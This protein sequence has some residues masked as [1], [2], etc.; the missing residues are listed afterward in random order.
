[1]KHDI[2]QS[3]QHKN[4]L[5]SNVKFKVGDLIRVSALHCGERAFPATIQE[6]FP[7]SE[8]DFEM[9]VED[10]EEDAFIVHD[11]LFGIVITNP[12]ICQQS[13]FEAF[14]WEK[15]YFSNGKLGWIYSGSIRKIFNS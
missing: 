3:V 7:G 6:I 4:T 8:V 10:V 9:H 1:M 5:T 13:K 14:C 2:E 12:K 11:G 15:V